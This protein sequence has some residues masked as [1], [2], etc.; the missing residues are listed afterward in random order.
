MSALVPMYLR[1][2]QSENPIFKDAK[3]IFSAYDNGFNGSLGPK[4]KAG[5]EFDEIDPAL[6][7]GL[8]APTTADLHKLA[9]KYADFVV[10]GDENTDDLE[11]Y[12]KS[13]GRRGCAAAM[14]RDDVAACQLS[15]SSCTLLTYSVPADTALSLHPW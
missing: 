9:A 12:A 14:H 2:F 8:D 7:E 10:L 5:M 4:L 13:A 15:A 11:E 1:L 6:T 3:V